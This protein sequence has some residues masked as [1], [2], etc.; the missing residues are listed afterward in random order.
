VA[1][2]RWVSL[3]QSLSANV[4]LQDLQAHRQNGHQLVQQ[5]L[6]PGPEAR[7]GG[8]L[9]YRQQAVIAQHRQQQDGARRGLAQTG[10]NRQIVRRGLGEQDGRALQG[11]LADQPLAKFDKLFKVRALGESIGGEPAQPVPPA[12]S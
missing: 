1:A 10:A 7:E 5:R 9:Q 11:A 3:Q 4:A 2:W 6:L 12:S 8:Q